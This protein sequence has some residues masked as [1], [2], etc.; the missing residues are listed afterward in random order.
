MIETSTPIVLGKLSE[1]T[2][3]QTHY[4][5]ANFIAFSFST[6]DNALADFA[7]SERFV[8]IRTHATNIQRSGH[9]KDPIEEYDRRLRY[10]I[11]YWLAHNFRTQQNLQSSARVLLTHNQTSDFFKVLNDSWQSEHMFGF[12]SG[13]KYHPH[14]LEIRPDEAGRPHVMHFFEIMPIATV[15]DAF[16]RKYHSFISA[17]DKNPEFFANSLF[18]ALMF[19]SNYHDELGRESNII[20]LPFNKYEFEYAKKRFIVDYSLGLA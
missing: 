11:Y 8:E 13:S 4:N 20:R 17:K 9:W 1:L 19:G 18:R 7:Q 10:T 16:M 6:V 2:L 5:E 12:R 14:G 3:E 15:G